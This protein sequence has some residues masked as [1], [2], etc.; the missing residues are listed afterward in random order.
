[1]MESGGEGGLGVKLNLKTF[2]KVDMDIDFKEDA[3]LVA[4]AFKD[5]RIY[6]RS[7]ANLNEPMPP[8]LETTITYD[9]VTGKW[10]VWYRDRT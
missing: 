1:M 4:Q 6:E 3:E 9:K 2:I 7:I 10:T 5:N 8:K